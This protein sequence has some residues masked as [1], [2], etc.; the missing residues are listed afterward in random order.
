MSGICKGVRV[1]GYF[2]CVG[3]GQVV[4]RDR[5]RLCRSHRAAE[6]D[7]HHRCQRPLQAA[8]ACANQRPRR[9]PVAQGSGR[10]RHH[11]RQSRDLS[12][13]P[14]GPGFSRRAG[15]LRCYASGQ[16]EDASRASPAAACIA[17]PLMAATSTALR[18]WTAI[19][20]ISSASST[21]RIR[22]GR[23]WSASGGC[24]G[25]GLPAAK[26]RPGK[27][28][29]HRCHHPMRAR[30][31]ALRQL[32]ARRLRDSRHRRHEQA[33]VRVRVSTGRRRFPGRPTRRCRCRFL[34]AAAA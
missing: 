20:A 8:L 17:L 23:N 4:V 24:R 15:G 27:A 19:S 3:G 11:A 22:S 18:R 33:E 10:K 31:S 30:Q 25:S 7:E 5:C 12:D 2:D 29:T 34:C 13:R 9:D 16:S 32:L 1:V 28:P 14:P 21:S 26:R 6:R